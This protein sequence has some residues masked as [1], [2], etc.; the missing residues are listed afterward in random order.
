MRG[1]TGPAVPLPQPLGTSDS[2]MFMSMTLETAEF[3]GN[4]MR[5]IGGI[6][7]ETGHGNLV[8]DGEDGNVSLSSEGDRLTLHA[9][10][11]RL[12][13]NVLV[14][15]IS[16][17]S[18]ANPAPVGRL[19]TMDEDGRL[20]WIQSSESHL[21]METLEDPG[22]VLVQPPSRINSVE[23]RSGGNDVFSGIFLAA[24]TVMVGS[25]RDYGNAWRCSKASVSFTKPGPWIVD[26]GKEGLA[27]ALDGNDIT[28]IRWDDGDTDLNLRSCGSGRVLANGA[29]IGNRDRL[30]TEV[31]GTHDI[32]LDDRG[33]H[34]LC[35]A[36][37]CQVFLRQHASLN[38]PI[39]AEIVVVI[40]EMGSAVLIA[41]HHVRLVG[42]GISGGEV[43]LEPC[44]RLTL[45][46]IRN[47][48]WHA[49]LA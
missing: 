11:I 10:N 48:A 21:A 26:S 29:E 13:G 20:G 14:D 5:F 45:L 15:R 6:S 18:I 43:V 23:I 17:I 19:V 22:L 1:N 28:A 12:S 24:D 8:V 7:M 35:D 44:S 39:G 40:G 34:L 31:S 25:P 49:A 27:L 2:P 4:G 16:S 32:S 41:E 30:Q 37:D 47:D 33:R 9:Q 42:R 38:M 3:N 46:K 36:P